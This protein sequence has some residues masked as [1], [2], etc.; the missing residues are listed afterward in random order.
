MHLPK[1]SLNEFLVALEGFFNIRFFIDEIH[2]TVRIISIDSIVSSP[3]YVDYDK[4]ILS[5]STELE[6]DFPG[7]MLSV[8]M[9]SGDSYCQ[10]HLEPE[11]ALFDCL[12]P[13]VDLLGQLPTWP[14]CEIGDI[15]YVK[16]L[17]AY[18]T[19]TSTT[20]PPS[21]IVSTNDFWSRKFF[22]SP[23]KQDEL[24][25]SSLYAPSFGTYSWVECGNA[26]ADWKDI[27]LR[28]AFVRRYFNQNFMGAYHST[29]NYNLWM[30]QESSSI[31][32][33]VMSQWHKKTLEFKH[34]TR[35]V[36][37]VKLMTV[38]EFQTL[39]FSKKVMIHGVK[40]LIKSIQVNFKKNLIAPAL[41]DLYKC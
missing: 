19:V 38:T 6:A 8:K 14:S 37:V 5:I 27:S 24:P 36:K 32:N 25:M 34:S 1:I 31:P 10:T 4:D 2:K 35:L 16:S 9:D 30:K 39:D 11:M 18:Y 33:T 3:D 17:N 21:W 28:L 22:R 26:L 12:K 13:E 7:I 23:D 40:Y 20:Y 41:L 29:T 15:R